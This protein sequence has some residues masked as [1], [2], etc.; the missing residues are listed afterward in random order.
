MESRGEICWWERCKMERTG[1]R[2]KMRMQ[3]KL[4][5]GREILIVD[6]DVSK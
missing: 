1:W 4:I 6:P 2:G 3:G 5:R